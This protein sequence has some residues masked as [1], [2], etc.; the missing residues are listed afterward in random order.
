MIG[1]RALQRDRVGYVSKMRFAISIAVRRRD[2]EDEIDGVQIGLLTC[3]HDG[4][5]VL[6]PFARCSH[7]ENTASARPHGLA[8]QERLLFSR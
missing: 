3:S 1:V 4:D 5:E 6:E 8:A 2:S 7:F